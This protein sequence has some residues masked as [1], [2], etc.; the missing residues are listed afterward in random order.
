MSRDLEYAAQLVAAMRAAG[1][2]PNEDVAVKLVARTG[3]MIRFGCHGERKGKRNGYAILHLDGRPAGVFGNWA[4]QTKGTWRADNHSHGTFS[5]HVLSQNRIAKVEATALQI[6]E[7]AKTAEQLLAKSQ[8]AKESH[9]Y[10]VLKGLP[11]IGLRQQHDELLVPL[12][13]IFGKLWNLQRINANGSKFYLRGPRRERIFWSAALGLAQDV[14][15]DPE[16]IYLGEGVAT[17]LAVHVATKTSV[18]AA[19]DINGLVPCA[20]ALRNRFPKAQ[21][22]VC[23]DDDAKTAERIGK[24]PGMIAAEAAAAA[25]GGWI[26][27]PIARQ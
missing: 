1:I 25:V 3:E 27:I 16:R 6:D 19:M 17:M 11:P 4:T 21:I 24:N 2:H 12:T 5:R 26:A 13:D 14:A 9:P 23:A 18:A 15:R 10:L 20:V 8:P 22:V 7:V